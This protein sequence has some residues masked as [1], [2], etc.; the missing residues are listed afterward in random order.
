MESLLDTINVRDLLSTQ[1]LSDP[2]SPLSAPDLRLLIQRLESHSLHIKSKVQSYLVSHHE[3]FA[4]LFSLC[5]DAVSQSDHI[6]DGVSNMLH[7]ISDRPAD[8][9]VREVLDE[10]KAKREELKVK[11]ELLGLVK[12]IV[13]VNGKLKGVREGLANGRLKFAAE[14]L[15]DLRMLLG[16]TDDDP[17]VDDREPVFL[18]LKG[19]MENIG[20]EMPRVLVKF[21]EKAVQ[22]DGKSNRVVVKYHL[23]VDNIDG[24]Q[25]Q[26]VMEAMDVVG[27]LEYG[28][29]KVA[30]LMIKY[31]IAPFINCGRPIQLLEEFNP[32]SAILKTS[33]IGVVLCGKNPSTTN[34]FFSFWQE[35]QIDNLDGEFLYSG[36]LLVI[37]FIYRSFCYQNGSWIRCFGRLTWPR[38][39]EII[40]SSFLSKVVPTNA[41]KLPDF[42]KII[43]C[44]CDFE[45]ALKELMFISALDDKDNRLSN[46]SENV[47]VHF[48][49]KKKIEILGKARNLLQG[50]DFAIPQEYTR[51]GPIGK[52][53][54]ISMQ[55]TRHVV[56]LLFLSERCLVSK[57]AK[58]LMELVH[59]TLQDVCL[60]STRVA[61]EFYHAA[62]DAML[63]YE[64]VVPIKLERQLDG[65]NQIAV[66]MHNDCLYFSQE[67]LG[68]AFE[69]QTDFP[70]SIKE[71]A[72]FVDLVP[73]FQLMAEEILQKQVHLVIY[74]L[75]EAIDGADGFQNTHH[76]QQFETAK[77]SIDQ[78]VF[79]LEKVHII[80]EPLLLPSTYR[81]SLCTILESVFSR[82]T[83]DILLLDDIAAEETL[84]LQ[85]LIHLML[86][87]LSSLLESLVTADQKLHDFSVESLDDLILSLRKIRKLSGTLYMPLKSITAAWENKELLAC[88]FTITEVADFIKAIF[89]DSPLRKECLW[90]I[91]NADF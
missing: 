64:V 3:D 2:T 87:N 56:D 67:I 86:E 72:V 24:I 58:Q 12:T 76:M 74:N 20:M 70:D 48:A 43:K 60:S 55:S 27:I 13:E 26:T 65:I 41:S 9:A 73:R 5:N 78:V 44:T 23:E 79:I 1:D 49:S 17:G 61:L 53:D 8:A 89:A 22:F 10:M 21:M 81:K 90:R 11:R 91:E 30:D 63:L 6:S 84:Q 40:I 52:N 16:V 66:L 34:W 36:I 37:K 46:F 51:D 59:H 18:A 71:H 39:S 15:R 42:Q 50:C 19:I 77:F 28:L 57:A 33:T 14:G 31:I 62:R 88:G 32:D 54:G 4:N 68:L 38:I 82:I 7:L 45:M 80:W 29:A 47:E 85:R 83:R 69:Y 75:K 25:L 35:D